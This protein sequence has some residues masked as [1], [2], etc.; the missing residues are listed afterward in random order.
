M[1]IK[2]VTP[3]KVI[4]DSPNS[5]ERGWAKKPRENPVRTSIIERKNLV[6]SRPIQKGE[7]TIIHTHVSRHGFNS[8]LPSPT[9]LFTLFDNR[10]IVRT[11]IIAGKEKNQ[12]SGYVFIR[13]K[14]G[15]LNFFNQMRFCLKKEKLNSKDYLGFINSKKF[16]KIYPGIYNYRKKIYSKAYLSKNGFME[17]EFRK[18][19]LLAK[20]EIEQAGFSLR[21]VANKKAGYFFD[22]VNFKKLDYT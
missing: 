10:K 1:R 2:K 13:P 15:V 5:I 4:N 22:G 12:I 19:F 7:K 6:I 14:K 3:T 11:S 20:K 18:D 16:Q 21:F 8:M 17:K 9:D